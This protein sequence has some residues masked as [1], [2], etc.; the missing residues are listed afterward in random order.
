MV[1]LFTTLRGGDGG[2]R[3]VTTSPPAWRL[4][5]VILLRSRG[6]QLRP[7]VL[8]GASLPAGLGA[9]RSLP[10]DECPEMR[11]MTSARVVK[12][13]RET[14]YLGGEV[15]EQGGGIDFGVDLR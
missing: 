15:I 9:L 7:S 13:E 6:A 1:R 3:G 2:A 4:L 10:R 8:P 12:V 14:R 5:G 11:A